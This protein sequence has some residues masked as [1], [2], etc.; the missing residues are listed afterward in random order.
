MDLSTEYLG[1]KLKNP[2]VAASSGLTGNLEGIKNLE[3]NGVGAVVLKSIFE[4]EILLEVRKQAEEADSNPLIYSELSE[5]LD[6]IDLHIKE[7]RL[8]SFLDLIRDAKRETE[9][10]S[11]IACGYDSKNISDK[12][13]IS[14]NTVNN[15]RQNI[16]RKTKTENTTQALLYCK[17]LGII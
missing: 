16:L 3:K 5:T 9:I 8:G 12:L 4:E 13:F 11:L 7:D 15:H 6:Y 1:L 2:L 14:I 17:R 10:L